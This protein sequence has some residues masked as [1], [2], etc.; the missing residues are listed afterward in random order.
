MPVP[1]PITQLQRTQS[2]PLELELEHQVVANAQA[3]RDAQPLPFTEA[4]PDHLLKFAPQEP[5]EG[6]VVRRA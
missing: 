6:G 2:T 4:P 3:D 1:P 5:E